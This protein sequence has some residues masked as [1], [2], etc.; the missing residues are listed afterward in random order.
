VASASRRAG[1]LEEAVSAYRNA[2]KERT[3]QPAQP[4]HI[5][6]Q[7]RREFA[8]LGHGLC[9]PRHSQTSTPARPATASRLVIGGDRRSSSGSL[10]ML[11]AMRRASSRVG[12]RY[13]GGSGAVGYFDVGGRCGVEFE[14]L[15]CNVSS[16]T[17]LENCLQTLRV[18]I[19][20]GDVQAIE[21]ALAQDKPGRSF[22]FAETIL[23]YRRIGRDQA[24]PEGIWQRYPSRFCQAAWSW[25][26]ATRSML[27][28]SSTTDKI[29]ASTN[30][31]IGANRHAAGL[32]LTHLLKLSAS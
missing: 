20:V 32:L 3:P 12:R 7:N 17:P 11:A 18:L 8:D 21:R 27:R 24:D 16:M 10:A 28:A 14:P 25:T 4:R 19:D 29:E 6:R 23:G 9:F 1:R 13:R 26:T 2:L 30:E 31:W 5:C 22:E 15:G